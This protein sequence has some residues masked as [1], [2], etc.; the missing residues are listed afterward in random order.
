MNLLKSKL[1]KFPF[2][3]FTLLIAQFFARNEKFR[4]FFLPYPIFFVSLQ[5]SIAEG[6]VIG[7]DLRL[8]MRLES[9]SAGWQYDFMVKLALAIIQSVPKL[10]GR[11][12]SL[13]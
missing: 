8:L 1:F 9:L 13:R 5:P 3:P 2:P 6:F 12:N 4:A 11:K 10:A 7:A